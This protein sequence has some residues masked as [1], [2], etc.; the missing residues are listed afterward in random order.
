MGDVQFWKNSADNYGGGMNNVVGSSPTVVNAVFAYNSANYAGGMRNANGSNSTLTN[1]SFWM[2]SADYNGGGMYNYDSS[3]TLT[4]VSFSYNTAVDHGGGIYNSASSPELFDVGFTRNTAGASGGGM[5]NSVSDPVVERVTFSGN[6]AVNYGGGMA[7]YNTSGNDPALINVVFSGNTA[8]GTGGGMYN[9]NSDPA[10]TGVTFSGNDSANEFG[11][12]GMYNY[13]SDPVLLNTIMWGITRSLNPKPQIANGTGS[14]PSIY[15]S[16][17]QGC[18]DSGVWVSAC[19]TNEE[20]NIHA[21][22]RFVRNPSPGADGTWGTNDD[23]YGDLHLRMVSPVIDVGS[24]FLCPSVDLDGQPRPNGEFCD[25]G[26]Y[27]FW[28][29]EV[30]LPILLR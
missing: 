24:N 18:F 19:G 28:P 16:D 23:N 12:L 13:N 15:Y 25:M 1:V 20:G 10:L 9:E 11:T 8:D 14:D 5:Y 3:P 7:N 21:T 22:P 6:T 4:D 27:E 29:K 30:F 2:N 17:I 26:A